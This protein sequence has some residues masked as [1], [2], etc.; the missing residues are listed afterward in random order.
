MRKI[1]IPTEFAGRVDEVD[2]KDV[3]ILPPLTFDEFIALDMWSGSSDAAYAAWLRANVFTDPRDLSDETLATHHLVLVRHEGDPEEWLFDPDGADKWWPLW[4]F[5]PRET[6]CQA[7]KGSDRK[8][9]S[10]P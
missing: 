9:R 8:D 4:R 2:W 3:L 6:R 7:L 5:G 1:L 10:S